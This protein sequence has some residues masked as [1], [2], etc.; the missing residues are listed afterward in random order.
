MWQYIGGFQGD[1]QKA[2]SG[3][4]CEKKLELLKEEGV[5]FNEKGMLIEKTCWWDE[6][7][8]K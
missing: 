8:A 3:I 4:N 5:E 7:V 6:F 2:P 1:W